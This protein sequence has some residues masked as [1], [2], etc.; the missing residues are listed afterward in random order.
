MSDEPVTLEWIDKRIEKL[1]ESQRATTDFSY[2]NTLS[3]GR[4]AYERVRPAFARMT[5][6]LAAAEGTMI[7]E[8]W[9]RRDG[10]WAN[11]T[12]EELWV[13]ILRGFRVG[14][15]WYPPKARCI[16][17]RECSV[18]NLDEKV[19]DIVA[20]SILDAIEKGEAWLAEQVGGSDG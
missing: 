16:D 7:R 20:E 9:V 2:K 1:F 19:H 17:Y 5:E 8:G 14:N 6:E 10:A 18:E 12:H 13:E 4:V 15:T 3:A 11:F